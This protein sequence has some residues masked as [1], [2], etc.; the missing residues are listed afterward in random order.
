M[1]KELDMR[2]GA[3]GLIWSQGQLVTMFA[4]MLHMNPSLESGPTGNNVCSHVANESQ[5]GVRANW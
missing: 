1:L 2:L 5:S 4:H 3:G